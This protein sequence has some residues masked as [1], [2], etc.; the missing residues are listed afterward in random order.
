MMP[1]ATTST[2]LNHQNT[3][4]SLRAADPKPNHQEKR[5]NILLYNSLK[6]RDVQSGRLGEE[7]TKKWTPAI[8]IQDRWDDIYSRFG[9][10]QERATALM[11]AI[12]DELDKITDEP[13]E[14]DNWLDLYL[15]GEKTRLTDLKSTNKT[16]EACLDFT[17]MA[18]TGALSI[19]SAA[20]WKAYDDLDSESAK[21]MA[22]NLGI[23]AGVTTT[24]LATKTIVPKYNEGWRQTPAEKEL[25]FTEEM[26]KVAK[27]INRDTEDKVY[28][29]PLPPG[30]V[31]FKEIDVFDS[32]KQPVDKGEQ[33]HT[34]VEFITQI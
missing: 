20:C 15:R 17:S 28:F 9:V 19:M 34:T 11:N 8:K 32:R 33:S 12:N 23:V 7:T 10:K 30:E 4:V 16:I 6:F 2:T 29:L 1:I 22:R 18:C 13:I 25:A 21:G 27:D 31:Q 14:V 5:S 3:V 26:V 24:F